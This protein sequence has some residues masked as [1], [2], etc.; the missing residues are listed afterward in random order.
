MIVA[1]ELHRIYRLQ[2]P[3][4]FM[5]LVLL[6]SHTLLIYGYS[7]YDIDGVDDAIDQCPDTPFDQLAETDGCSVEQRKIGTFTITSGL[8]Y[9]KSNDG[10]SIQNLLFSL[11]YRYQ[12]WDFTLSTFA[13]LQQ[14]RYTSPNT[15]YCTAAYQLPTLQSWNLQIIGGI[16][17]SSVQ[18]DYSAALSLSR[19]FGEFSLYTYYS[20]TYAAD[21][22]EQQYDNY[23]T[24]SIGVDK[25]LT[26]KWYT[27][28]SFD[29]ATPSFL[30]EE[31]YRAATLAATYL[32]NR[33]QFVT[34]SY[35]RGIGTGAAKNSLII[36]YG[37][38]F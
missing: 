25:M 18:N 29:Y 36:R 14:E 37:I 24:F 16:K 1:R 26:S 4:I 9:T 2:S 13:T 34:S 8:L 33:D 11:D 22:P 15:L 32:L 30:N 31:S 12:K 38:H 23:Y 10:N 6:L 27:S 19:D 3:K 20:Y 5:I 35:I 7:D 17:L 21:A 28:L